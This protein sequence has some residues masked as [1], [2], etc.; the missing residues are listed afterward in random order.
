MTNEHMENVQNHQP[1]NANLNQSEVSTISGE[2]AEKVEPP[3]I[4]GGNVQLCNHFG[5]HFGSFKTELLHD[6]AIEC[7]S[8]TQEN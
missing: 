6:P 2:N 7:T 5:K 3:S 1:L 8:I 4:A